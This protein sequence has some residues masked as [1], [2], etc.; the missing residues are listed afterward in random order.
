MT[1]INRERRPESVDSRRKGQAQGKYQTPSP[2]GGEQLLSVFLRLVSGLLALGFEQWQG[3]L[4]SIAYFL[5]LAI[6]Q[7]VNTLVA[8]TDEVN[9][10]AIVAHEDARIIRKVRFKRAAQWR[11]VFAT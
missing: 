1:Q 7:V 2:G 3:L 10:L 8:F 4:K 6:A 5:E 9:Q 11:H